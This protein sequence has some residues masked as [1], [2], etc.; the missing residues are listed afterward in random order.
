MLTQRDIA[1]TP[2]MANATF[3]TIAPKVQTAL[4]VAAVVVATLARTPM[5][6][7]ATFQTIVAKAPTI[8]IAATVGTNEEK[9]W[10]DFVCEILVH[11]GCELLAPVCASTLRHFCVANTLQ[12]QCILHTRPNLQP[13]LYSQQRRAICS[14]MPLPGNFLVRLVRDARLSTIQ[15]L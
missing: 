6:E 15:G 3:R 8:Q 13:L 5:M 10:I 12:L 11:E 4:T 9:K 7:N 14:E 2:A 1:Q